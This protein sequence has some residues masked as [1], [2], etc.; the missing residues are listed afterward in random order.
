MNKH[1][2]PACESE[3]KY[4]FEHQRAEREYVRTSDIDPAKDPELIALKR[5]YWEY[6][7]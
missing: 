2:C 5:K 4:C 7:E 3:I 6:G 1:K